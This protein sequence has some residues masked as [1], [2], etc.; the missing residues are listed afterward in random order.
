MLLIV[1]MANFYNTD[2]WI[3][4]DIYHRGEYVLCVTKPSSLINVLT[5]YLQEYTVCF[6]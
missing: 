2:P 6:N 1:V 4:F 5:I 3:I